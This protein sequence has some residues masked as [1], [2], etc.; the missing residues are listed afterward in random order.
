MERRP[1]RIRLGS[2]ASYRDHFYDHPRYALGH[3]DG[4]INNKAKVA[5]KNCVNMKANLART[6][7]S[8]ITREQVEQGA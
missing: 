5:C 7:D 6:P 1:I 3:A 2:R 4:A 8:E